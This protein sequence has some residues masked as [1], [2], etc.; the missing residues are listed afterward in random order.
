MFIKNNVA[1]C[2]KVFGKTEISNNLDCDVESAARKDEKCLREN[3]LDAG[4]NGVDSLS[5]SSDDKE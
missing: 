3:L 5:N 1:A 2:K 4:N